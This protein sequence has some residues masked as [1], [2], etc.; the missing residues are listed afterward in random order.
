[1]DKNV[2]SESKRECIFY[3][4]ANSLRRPI[5][6]EAID[7]YSPAA[8]ASDVGYI[9]RVSGQKGPTRHV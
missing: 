7:K 2:C 4:C 1:M 9:S 6:P 8:I 5:E 3:Q